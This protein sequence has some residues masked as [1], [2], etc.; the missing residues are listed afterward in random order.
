MFTALFAKLAGSLKGRNNCLFFALA[1][2]WRWRK[3]GAY[4]S[5]RLSR[6]ITGLHWV[7]HYKGRVIHYEPINPKKTWFK[8]AIDKIWY[9]GKIHRTD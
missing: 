1:A 4:L 2:W 8:A 7:V 5:W 9:R 3:K 6:N